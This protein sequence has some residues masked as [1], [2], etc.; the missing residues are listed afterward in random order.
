MKKALFA[1]LFIAA[2]AIGY[3]K[4]MPPVRSH[5]L[6]DASWKFNLGDAKDASNTAF[7]DAAWRNIDLPHDWSVEGEFDKDAPTG[8]GGGYLPTGIGWYRKAFKMPAN[9]KGK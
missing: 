1:L 6:I 7:N 4:P 5:L 3:A 2:N 8:G 9:A